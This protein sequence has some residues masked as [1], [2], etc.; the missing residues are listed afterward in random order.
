MT[1]LP[2]HGPMN[3]R[4]CWRD[5]DGKSVR[6][7]DDGRFRL[8]ND[9][10]AWGSS[11]PIV[12][13]LGQTKGN[14]QCSE[15]QKVLSKGAFDQVAFKRF[16]PNLLRVL[17]AVSVL[18]RTSSVDPL[19]TAAEPNFGWGSVIRCSMT[20][21]TERTGEYSG[22]SGK[23][24][25]AYKA[26]EAQEVIRTCMR[27]WLKTLPERTRLIVLLGNS[28]LYIRR[29]REKLRQVHPDTIPHPQAPAVAH[30]AE[31]RT[32]VHVGHP[33]GANGYLSNFLHDDE[34][35][36]QGKKRAD[37]TRAVRYELD[38]IATNW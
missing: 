16:R 23:V 7:L 38:K 1:E 8:V 18:D 33:S 24:L 36:G 28:D 37:A 10:G 4:L 17:K 2:K 14:T 15:M 34:G 13:V 11:S 31:G 9:P 3:C 5:H 35:S 25:P 12:L 22:D 6:F 21:L 29:M 27:T 20:G 32:W 26:D 30:L 19:L